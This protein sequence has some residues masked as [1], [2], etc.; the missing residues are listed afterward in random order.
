M[1]GYAPS[2]YLYA[3]NS[4]NRDCQR[5]L[6]AKGLIYKGNYSGWY[7]VTDECF[8]TDAQVSQATENGTSKIISLETGSVVEWQEETNYMLRLS[9]FQSALLDHYKASPTSNTIFPPHHQSHIIDI[10]SQPLE[11]LSISRPRSRLSWGVQV[12]TDPDQTVYVWFDALLGYLSGLQYPWNTTNTQDS[13]ATYG[14]PVDLQ[15]IGKDILRCVVPF[16]PSSGY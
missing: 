10:L 13:P 12:P 16:P 9:E 8:Y 15:V 7:S 3:S 6:D 14:W 11:D 4:R 2:S 5:I 1:F